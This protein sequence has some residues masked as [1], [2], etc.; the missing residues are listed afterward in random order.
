MH[1]PQLHPQPAHP[2]PAHPQPAHPQPAHPQPGHPTP[3]ERNSMPRRSARSALVFALLLAPLYALVSVTWALA[4]WGP[5]AWAPVAWAPAA[6]AA[7]AVS[8]GH[9]TIEH[10]WARPTDMLATTGAVYFDLMNGGDA[11]DRLIAART[12]V[13]EAAE[14]HRTVNDGGMLR[15]QPIAAIDIPAKGHV[16][17][18]PGVF[19]VMLAHLKAPLTAGQRF[20]LQLTFE[21]AGA[22]TVEVVVEKG[23][24]ASSAMPMGPMPM[25]QMP[26]GSMP[27]GPMPKGHGDKLAPVPPSNGGGM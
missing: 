11:A 26:M 4:A 8:V 21:K 25:G 2:Q 1:A 6:W 20:P 22:V 3:L 19:H 15:M 18:K 7:D 13:A 12:E 5:V 17:I 24:G 14:L 23:D 27:M 9:M 16:S 10:P